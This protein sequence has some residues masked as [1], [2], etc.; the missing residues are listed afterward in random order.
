[1]SS[2]PA[3]GVLPVDKPEGP[4]SHDVVQAARRALGQR[5]IGHTGTLD[6]FASGLMLLCVGRATRIA[7]FL[8]GLDKSYDAVARLGVLTD[9]LDREG[10]VLREDEGWRNL[11]EARVEGALRGFVGSTMQVPPQY[12]A[13]KVEGVAMHRRARRGERIELDPRPVTIHSIELIELDLPH[14][15]FRL[16]CSS[17]TY[18]RSL[19]RDVGEALGVGAHLTELRRTS[20][21]R[22]DL[23]EAL[24]PDQLSDPER[25]K[26]AWIDPLEALAHVPHVAVDEHA[27]AALER[28]Q[29]VPVP[30]ALPAALA[31]A[32]FGGRL[33]AV[34]E[35]ADHLFRPRKV[36]AS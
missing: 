16:R 25:V 28:G 12:S 34:G 31:V 4:T 7:E 26:G 23:T 8:T 22:F 2:T 14:V 29:R 9:T 15:R 24:H 21:G 11:E 27:V 33:V 19:A 13:R 10:E 6:P 30:E 36:F 3:D 18:V 20:V 32:A 17:G 1:V 35:V 5:R